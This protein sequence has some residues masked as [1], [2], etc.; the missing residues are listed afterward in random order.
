MENSESRAHLPDKNE[1]WESQCQDGQIPKRGMHGQGQGLL[2]KTSPSARGGGESVKQ[3]RI[4][5]EP[6]AL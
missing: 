1:E 6:D 3:Q 5:K 2:A 4:S